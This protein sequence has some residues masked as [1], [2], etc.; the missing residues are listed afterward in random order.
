MRLYSGSSEQFIE[1]TTQNQI[2]E[3]MRDSFFNYFRFYPSPSEINSWRNSLRA[4]SLVMLSS[5][6]DDHGVL[7]EYQLPLTSKRLDFM[8]C[9][10]DEQSRDQAVIIE[11]KQWE[12]CSMADGEREVIT[13]VGG[14]NREVLHPSAQVNQ[15][16]LYLQDT[17]TAFYDGASPIALNACAYLHNYR[18]VDE[19]ALFADKFRNLIETCPV[20]SEDDVNKLKGYL[21]SRLRSGQGLEVLKRVEDSRYRP[22]K[23]L[24]DHI[25]EVIKGKPEYVLLDEQLIVYDK[26]L[27]WASKGFNYPQKAVVIV[28][29]GPGTGKSVI[30]MN[31]LADLSLKGWNAHYATG[32]RAFTGTLREIIGP[33]GQVQFKFFNNYG[34]CET[35]SV[36][37]LIADEAHRIRETSNDRF[38]PAARRSGLSQIDELIRAAKV[39]VFFIDDAQV[40]R[41][42]ETGSVDYIKAAAVK[43]G[44]KTF[45]YQLEAQFRC[46]G[47]DAFVNWIDNTLGI[48]RT[49]NILWEGN[50]NFEFRIMDSPAAIEN[51]LRGKI[52]LGSTARMTAGF[53]WPWSNPQADGTLKDDVVVGEYRRPWNAKS[54][55]K[56]AKG[57]PKEITWAYDPKGFDQVGCVYTA[58]GFEFDYAGVIIGPDLRYNFDLQAWEGHKETS[59]DTVVKRSGDRFLDLVKNTYR[60]LLTRGMKGCY[61][62]FMDKDTERFFR[63]RMETNE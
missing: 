42:Y 37:C 24:M 4:M 25:G 55:T 35:N 57:I 47:S 59:F 61:V 32:S 60:V 34:S 58:Q 50:E 10:K 14:G 9:G 11:L 49:A 39:A 51:E 46:S 41:P 29:G 16:M 7:L 53:C 19:D 40:V 38:T 48:R 43:N 3:K 18:F 52:A 63:S 27:T 31:L 33:R 26:V 21:Q 30:A 54:G 45:E 36:D 28:K 2:A 6:L 8:V 20:F 44:C 22:S 23:K 15:Y 5:K 13:Y 62:H 1:D 56:L 12:K 17:H